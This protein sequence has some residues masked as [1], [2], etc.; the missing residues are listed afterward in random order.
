M[1]FRYFEVIFLAHPSLADE[2]GN[3]QAR[4]RLSA[5]SALRSGEML[6]RSQVSNWK[7]SKQHARPKM[8]CQVVINN[9]VF[10][11]FLSVMR[12]M[13]PTYEPTAANPSVDGIAVS[14]AGMS[15]P[16]RPENVR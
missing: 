2:Y 7:F 15:S 8:A 1:P 3:L 6:V 4:Y 14:K 12:C 11:D 13:K 9:F 5:Q 10:D 16:D